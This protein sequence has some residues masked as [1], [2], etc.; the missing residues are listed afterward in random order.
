MEA[1]KTQNESQIS[2][3]QLL[4]L[5]GLMF[6]ASIDN[7]NPDQPHKPGPWDPFIREALEYVKVF[8]PFPE[9]WRERFDAGRIFRIIARRFPQIWDAA[10]NGHSFD[11]VALNPQPLPPRYAFAESFA[12]VLIRRAELMRDVIA[13][14]PGENFNERGIIVVGGQD[15]LMTID[16]MCGNGFRLNR[17]QPRPT[18]WTDEFDALGYLAMAAR[19][20]RAK[21]E[22][23]YED[24]RRD[25][26]EAAARLI[27]AGLTRLK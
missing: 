1:V 20:E 14:L 24:L 18:W 17:P 21:R 6:G 3:G 13:N 23:V 25:F 22:T 11:E 15:F 8:G 12:R 27:D 10:V 7:P 16:E 2:R 4:Q 9:P 5:V 26:H 19:F